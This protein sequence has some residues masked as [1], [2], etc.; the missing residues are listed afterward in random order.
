MNA[1]PLSDEE[2]VF[3][4]RNGDMD[5]FTR[6]VERNQDAI[7][8]TVSAMLGKNVE[9]DDIV[10]EVF[11][12]FFSTL[13]RFR[14]DAAPRTYLKRIAINRSLD[15]IRRRK[16]TQLFF[17]SME[18]PAALAAQQRAQPTVA[19]FDRA[20]FV[21]QAIQSLRPHHRSVV[22]LRLIEG[23]S[24]RET[25]HI[26]EIPAGTV[27]SRLSRASKVLRTALQHLRN[28]DA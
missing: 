18:S 27:L 6:L 20:A 2:L 16:R 1:P 11:I 19:D 10:Q 25:A 28:D 3:L 4:A 15:A 23:Y 17:T 12:R 22:V 21:Q 24:T 26:L 8:R 13:H 14:G 5:A 9:V 7:T